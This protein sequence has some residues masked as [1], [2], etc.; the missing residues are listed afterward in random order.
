MLKSDREVKIKIQ[1][2]HSIKLTMVEM[3]FLTLQ[4]E[5]S[6]DACDKAGL[7]HIKLDPHYQGLCRLL[8]KFRDFLPAW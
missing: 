3:E 2:V 1:Q 8:G 6:I 4:L 7:S 5:T